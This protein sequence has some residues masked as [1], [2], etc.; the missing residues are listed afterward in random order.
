MNLNANKI[1]RKK[2]YNCEKK[3]HIAKRYKK[4]KSTQQFNTLKEY[5]DERIRKHF[6]EK[7]TRAQVLKENEQENN[8]EKDLKYERKCVFSTTC[9]Y[10]PLH[11]MTPVIDKKT[12]RIESRSTFD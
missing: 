8:F 12:K 1:N 5:L 10:R 4:L 9:I 7:K 6:W 3:N 11:S 2:Y